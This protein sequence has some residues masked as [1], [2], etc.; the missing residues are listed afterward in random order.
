[1][2]SSKTRAVLFS[3]ALLS[4]GFYTKEAKSD[5]W[6]PFTLDQ[7]TDAK[8]YGC[9][10]ITDYKIL[11]FVLEEKMEAQ[12][13]VLPQEEYLLRL[14]DKELKSRCRGLT[15][16]DLINGEVQLTQ[17]KVPYGPDCYVATIELKA[18]KYFYPVCRYAESDEGD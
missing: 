2:N 16:D 8:Q 18:K 6:Y 17:I 10:D 7:Y 3:M 12:T 4:V 5:E 15:D 14:F 11:E 13:N 9:E 1:M